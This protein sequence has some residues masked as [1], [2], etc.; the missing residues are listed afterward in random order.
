MNYQ[1]LTEGKKYQISVRLEQKISVS[2][3]AKTI[4]C[5]KATVYRELKRNRRSKAY[6]PK[7][8]SHKAEGVQ[9]VSNTRNDH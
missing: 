7:K 9:K 1:Q 6:C 5:H 8:V 2:E 4:Q 3:I